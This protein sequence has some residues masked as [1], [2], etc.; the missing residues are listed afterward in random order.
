MRQ[1]DAVTL[2]ISKDDEPI[3]WDGHIYIEVLETIKKER[4]AVEG[5]L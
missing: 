1:W 3:Y 2:R 5:G 4:E